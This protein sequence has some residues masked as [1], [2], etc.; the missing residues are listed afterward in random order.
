[1]FAFPLKVD[2]RL[3]MLSEVKVLNIGFEKVKN[4]ISKKA[5]SFIIGVSGLS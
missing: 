5:F 4:A 2:I 1:M 3:F